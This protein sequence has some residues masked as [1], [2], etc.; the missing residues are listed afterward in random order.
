MQG[1]QFA[2]PQPGLTALFDQPRRSRYISRNQS[3]AHRF[4]H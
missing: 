2:P 3:M 4:G 1:R